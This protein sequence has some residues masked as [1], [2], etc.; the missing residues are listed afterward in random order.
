MREAAVWILCAYSLIQA[1][2]IWYFFVYKN[3]QADREYKRN[4][5]RKN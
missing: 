4:N 2:V 5:E 3:N 1:F